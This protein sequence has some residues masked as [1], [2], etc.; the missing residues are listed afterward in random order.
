MKMVVAQELSEVCSASLD[1]YLRSACV[2]EVKVAV[3]LGKVDTPERHLV[4]H[5]NVMYG[6]F[7][8]R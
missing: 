7:D 8:R 5:A 3:V 6:T 4:M 1:G 2:V